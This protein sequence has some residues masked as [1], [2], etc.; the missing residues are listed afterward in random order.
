M[1]ASSL[2]S[3]FCILAGAAAFAQSKGDLVS[4]SSEWIKT[5]KSDG[6]AVTYVHRDSLSNSAVEAS[7]LSIYKVSPGSSEI[8][9]L[10]SD[11]S[12]A[13]KPDLDFEPDSCYHANQVDG[14]SLQTWCESGYVIA[15]TGRVHM[16]ARERAQAFN[17]RLSEAT[18]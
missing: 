1:R 6:T 16:G 15:E 2:F 14:R 5:E 8:K 17:Q 9:K 3:I 7:T 18:K 12:K 10:L 4:A 11:L 13:S